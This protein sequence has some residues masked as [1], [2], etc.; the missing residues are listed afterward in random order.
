MG[1][2]L[3]EDELSQALHERGMYA[4]SFLPTLLVTNINASMTDTLPRTE[5]EPKLKWWL[6]SAD[7]DGVGGDAISRRVQLVATAAARRW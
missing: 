7:A 1:A 2:L 5:W 4:P 3:S 6:A